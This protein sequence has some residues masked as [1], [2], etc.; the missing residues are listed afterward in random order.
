VNGRRTKSMAMG[1]KIFLSPSFF[2]EYTNGAPT[3]HMK[4]VGKRIY[5][6]VGV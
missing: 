6:Q 1:L 2:T 3:T 5:N 4:A